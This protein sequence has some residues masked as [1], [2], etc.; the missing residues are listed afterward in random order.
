[1]N[2]EHWEDIIEKIKNKF[3]DAAHV[4]E[5]FV[6]EENNTGEKIMGERERIEFVSPVGKIRLEK[7][8]KPMVLDKRVLYSKRIGSDIKVD[9]VYSDKDM[10]EHINIYRLNETENVWIKLDEHNFSF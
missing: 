10:V 3:S 7:I 2:P 1:M 6:V 4:K 9:R 8:R 5:D